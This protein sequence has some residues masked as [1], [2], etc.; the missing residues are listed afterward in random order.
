MAEIVVEEAFALTVDQ[1]LRAEQD[2][3]SHNLLAAEP[4]DYRIKPSLEFLGLVAS[5]AL[6]G[7]VYGWLRR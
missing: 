6:R 1:G 3:H 4:L 2:L 7:Q 5:I